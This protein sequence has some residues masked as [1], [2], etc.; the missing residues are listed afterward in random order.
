VD[1]R[2]HEGEGQS[3]PAMHPEAIIHSSHSVSAGI[4]PGASG[5]REVVQLP[6]NA[7]SDPAE[8]TSR[9]IDT[10]AG[11]P[12]YPLKRPM[13]LR[14]VEAPTQVI[15]RPLDLGLD[16]DLEGRGSSLGSAMEDFG[17]RFDLLIQQNRAVPPH[18][19][20]PENQRI[21]RILGELV[22][23]DRYERDN[24]LVQPMWGQIRERQADGSL[25]IHWIIGPDRAHDSEAPLPARHVPTSLSEME[26]GRWFYGTARCHPDRIEWIEEP[27]DVP[28]PEDPVARQA[29]WDSLPRIPADE[30]GCWP[31]KTS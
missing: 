19:R 29:L 14:V 18:A 30:P 27:L 6:D 3:L 23:W 20:T 9:F 21:A 24:P 28:D 17:R 16:E 2:A 13:A 1:N 11:R 5:R 22:D 4:G 26:V 12:S 8:E 7:S 25:R 31:L 15:V 10:V